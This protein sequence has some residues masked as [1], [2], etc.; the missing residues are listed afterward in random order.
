MSD[1]GPQFDEFRHTASDPRGAQHDEFS[2]DRKGDPNGGTLR[3]EYGKPHAA[4]QKHGPLQDEWEWQ[5]MPMR[6]GNLYDSNFGEH[7]ALSPGGHGTWHDVF[8]GA[9]VRFIQGGADLEGS[10]IDTKSTH[11]IVDC[12]TGRH[13]VHLDQITWYGHAKQALGHVDD[14]KTA[15]QVNVTG[16]N[17]EGFPATTAHAPSAHDAK[18]RG[19]GER[20]P[21]DPGAS[22]KTPLNKTLD[23]LAELAG[24]DIT[25]AEPPADAQ[26]DLRKLAGLA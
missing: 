16:I 6:H 26:A 21:L 23:E 19:G 1:H 25:K 10:V 20:R 7:V 13:E 8:R 22:S 9:R 3:D 14:V 2:R 12:S 5:A 15:T 4:D 18:A 11:A 17:A 24:L